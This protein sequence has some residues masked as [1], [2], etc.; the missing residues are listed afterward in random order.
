MCEHYKDLNWV[1]EVNMFP[2]KTDSDYEDIDELLCP[3]CFKKFLDRHEVQLRLKDNL[4][5]TMQ[6]NQK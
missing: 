6:E 3:N 1:L 2:Q 4:N 5:K